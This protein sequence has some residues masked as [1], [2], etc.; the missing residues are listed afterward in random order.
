MLR[1]ASSARMEEER[2]RLRG[3]P[4]FNVD[5]V[6]LLHLLLHTMASKETLNSVLPMLFLY[7]SINTNLVSTLLIEICFNLFSEK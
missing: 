6:F 7:S 2:D 4:L 3:H 1:V 5:T